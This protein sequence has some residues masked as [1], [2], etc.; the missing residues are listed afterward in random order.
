MKNRYVEQ[1]LRA[2]E[3]VLRQVKAQDFSLAGT[4]EISWQL[5][6]L[7]E[8]VRH[9]SPNQNGQQ[10][11]L[12]QVMPR[13][14]AILGTIVHQEFGWQVFDSQI[15]A[16]AA[17]ATGRVVELDTGEGKTLVAVFVAGLQALAGEPVHVLT[18]N[19]YLAGRDADWMSPIYR[20]LGLRVASIRQ[21]MTPA[22]RRQAYAADVTYL[23]AKEA[24]FDY[25]RD[26]LADDPEQCV[27]P[28]FHVA[29][30]DEA[31]SILIDEA[32]IPLVIAGGSS[33]IGA[34]DPALFRLVSRLEAEHHYQLDTY[35]D[36][37]LLT[38][39]GAAWLESRLGGVNLY[40]G[41]NSALL[42]QIH[43]ILQANVLLKRDIDYIVRDGSIQLVDEFTGRIV[44]DRQWPDGLHEAVEIKEGLAGRSRGRILNR[45]TL[46]DFI[47]LYPRLSGMTGT[48]WSA[49]PEFR[50]FY[51]LRV[52]RIPPNKPCQRQDHPDIIFNTR[53]GKEQAILAEIKRRHERGQPVLV[54]TASVEESER[55]AAA[56]KA[57]GLACT[58]LNA[59][60]NAAEAVI[61]A[62]AGRRGAITISTNMAGRGVDIR[63]E[64]PAGSGLCVIGTSRQRSVRIDRQLRG[65]AGRQGDPGESLF[66]I[67]LE[68]DLIERYKIRQ[69]LP[70]PY[71]QQ[72]PA[73]KSEPEPIIDPRIPR[74]V[75][76]TQRVVE[77][78]L[79]QQRLNLTR[80]SQLVDDQRQLIHRLHADIVTGRK[81]L[82]IWQEQS[83]ELAADLARQTSD[84]ELSRAQHLAGARLLNL[85]WA[86][87][88]EYVEQLL[89]HVSLMRTGPNDPFLTF[90]RQVVDAFAHFLDTFENEMVELLS[91]LVVRE[92]RILL[93][94]AGLASPPSTRT[95]LIDDGSDTLEQTLGI[96]DMVAVAANPGLML[97]LMANRKRKDIIPNE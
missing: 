8:D 78:Q 48:A 71:D 45:I 18:F 47:S 10:R 87:Y 13:F 26:F 32:R 70:P 97:V 3:R 31:D 83:A 89:N 65:R 5:N 28:P 73:L 69:I 67:S 58:V 44:R 79:Y 30:I 36:H 2:Y 55:L 11:R 39:A 53:Q 60:Q 24:G 46:H 38:T 72:P 21:G 86:D 85:G 34:I 19:D 4:D 56:V 82:T 35:G 1:N 59:R 91:H 62:E 20:R 74:L 29:I 37:V 52:T 23:T 50:E 95:Y 7:R 12:R 15:L 22:E 6:K 80:Y 14:F 94:E 64:E 25:L 57:N 41:E 63:L 49:A 93:E 75:D 27:Q 17:M 61:I 84:G 92:R 88:L 42:A 43:L 90:N 66:I 54:G 40:D 16:A 68:D 9:D 33:D 51:G 77:G 76:H 81:Q 96:S